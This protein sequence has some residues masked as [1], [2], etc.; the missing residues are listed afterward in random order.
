[1]HRTGAC[2]P[3]H[4]PLLTSSNRIKQRV[5]TGE[6]VTIDLDLDRHKVGSFMASAPSALINPAESYRR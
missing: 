2:C 6:V 3:I 1:M 4:T 5:I